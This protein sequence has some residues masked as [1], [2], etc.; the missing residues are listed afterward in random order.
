MALLP[1]FEMHDLRQLQRLMEVYRRPD[2]SPRDAMTLATQLAGHGYVEAGAVISALRATMRNEAAQAYL[3]RLALRHEAIQSLPALKPIFADKELML[4]FYATEGYMFR[5][6]TFRAETAI[7]I[8]TTMYNN[9]HFSNAVLDAILSPLGVSRLYLKDS[10]KYLYFQGVKGLASSLR[11]L[12]DALLS[13]LKSE[14]ITRY[15]ITGFSSG[16]YP[17]LYT[18]SKTDPVGYVGY[19][20][21]T[22]LSDRAHVDLPRIFLE[23]RDEVPPEMCLSPDD[24]LK[25]QPISYPCI[26]YYGGRSALDSAHAELLRDHEGIEVICL[27]DNFHET[28]SY[29]LETG[30]FTRPFQRFAGV[31]A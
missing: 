20:I 28:P 5:R 15:A 21:Y 13:L 23:I 27:P 12:P 11:E 31:C 26:V 16:G 29:L 14:G 17:S 10:S 25:G 19:S 2:L 22:D 6:G 7:V 1:Q 4:Q 9:F 18:A 8:F 24:M 3:A 30:E